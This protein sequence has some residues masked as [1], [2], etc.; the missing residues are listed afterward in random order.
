MIIPVLWSS[1]KSAGGLLSDFYDCWAELEREMCFVAVNAQICKNA[2]SPAF[3]A[4]EVTLTLGSGFPPS[5]DRQIRLDLCCRV[6]PADGFRS[7]LAGAGFRVFS[8]PTWQNISI[9][10]RSSPKPG[11]NLLAVSNRG[12][13][14]GLG[15]STS[16]GRLA[17]GFR[18]P[19][20][21]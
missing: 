20:V 21:I 1:G 13:G 5:V 18:N 17:A 7:S 8:P 12:N 6:A 4:R 19:T 10:R 14:A 15:A 2:A 9:I 3:W 16:W 11:E